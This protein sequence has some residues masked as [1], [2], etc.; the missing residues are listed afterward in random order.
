MWGGFACVKSVAAILGRS[1][2]TNRNPSKNSGISS[3][4][5]KFPNA[6]FAAGKIGHDMW[7][8]MWDVLHDYYTRH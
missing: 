2:Y 4:D 1:R 5:E 7:H 6:D 3:E 8:D